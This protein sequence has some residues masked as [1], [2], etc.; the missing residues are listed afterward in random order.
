MAG[1]LLRAVSRSRLPD[2]AWA[3]Q[4]RS[5]LLVGSTAKAPLGKRRLLRFCSPGRAG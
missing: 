1:H 4:F 5:F 3:D 2:G